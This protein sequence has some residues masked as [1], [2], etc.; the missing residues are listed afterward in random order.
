MTQPT[1]RVFDDPNHPHY[2]PVRR[3]WVILAQLDLLGSAES[4]EHLGGGVTWD[5]AIAR[6]IERGMA[7]PAAQRQVLGIIL[8][9]C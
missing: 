7:E 6:R 5:R 9:D 8:E 4:Y 3:M 1:K 2:G